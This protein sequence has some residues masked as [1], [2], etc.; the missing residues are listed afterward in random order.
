MGFSWLNPDQNATALA[1]VGTRRSAAALHAAPAEPL[2]V[3]QAH[4]EMQRHRECSADRCPLKRAARDALV[5]A[6]RMV[7]A[8]WGIED[9]PMN[10]AQAGLALVIAVPV[11]VIV[12][13]LSWPRPV[14]PDP[15]TGWFHAAPE[16]PFTVTQ[17]HNAMQAH[18]ECSAVDCPRKEAARAVLIEARRMVPYPRGY[19]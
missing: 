11:A 2:S 14:R 9:R 12:V 13:M 16:Q 5:R 17:A 3:E 18:R 15:Y 4:R 7:P 19:Q 10:A 6:G 8:G 1:A